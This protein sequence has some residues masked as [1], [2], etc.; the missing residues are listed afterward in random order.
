MSEI[1]TAFSVSHVTREAWFLKGTCLKIEFLPYFQP[2]LNK[3][4]SIPFL[5]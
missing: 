2:L 1:V 4:L 5:Q 3:V